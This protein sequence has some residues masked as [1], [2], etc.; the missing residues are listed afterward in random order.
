MSGAIATIGNMLPFSILVVFTQR[1]LGVDEAGYG[2][3]LAVSALGGLVGPLASVCV[4]IALILV[5]T[6][7][8]D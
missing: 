1:Q 7:D 6:V 8:V 3:I 4:S 2:L 5:R